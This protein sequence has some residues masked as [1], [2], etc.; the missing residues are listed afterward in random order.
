MHSGWKVFLQGQILKI[1]QTM[2]G[3]PNFGPTQT[4]L[5]T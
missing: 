4:T 5:S 1:Y 2:G 3:T